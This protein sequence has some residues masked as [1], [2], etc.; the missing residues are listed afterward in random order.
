MAST[1]TTMHQVAPVGETN[2]STWMPKMRAYL[3]EQKVWFIVSGEDTRP[4]DAAQAI[5]C[6]DKAATAA[7]AI[8]RAMELGQRL[9]VVGVEIDPVKMWEMLAA[10]HVQK[11]SGA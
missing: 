2:Y 10:V 4:S 7:G 11:V 3:A 1:K 8:Y 9:H 6:H 5:V